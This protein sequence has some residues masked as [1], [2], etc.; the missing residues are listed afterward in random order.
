MLASQ[1]R[2]PNHKSLIFVLLVSGALLRAPVTCARP[3]GELRR[4][5]VI[6]S[7][8]DSASAS[9]CRDSAFEGEATADADLF[10]PDSCPTPHG[11]EVPIIGWDQRL[12]RGPEL[13][14]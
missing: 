9:S 7:I 6:T 12:L 3:R 1:S 13:R 11:F 2:T 4:G 5:R 8:S 14:L 10:P